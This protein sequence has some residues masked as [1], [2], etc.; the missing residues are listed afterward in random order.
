MPPKRK[1]AEQSSA[2]AKPAKKPKVATKEVAAKPTK[3]SAKKPSA[4]SVAAP[5]ANAVPA[6][7]AV[8]ATIPAAAP[9]AKAVALKDVAVASTK[10]SVK[11]V[12]AGKFDWFS[13]RISVLHSEFLP[14]GARKPRYPELYAAI[15][16]FQAK[17]KYTGR[18]AL[19]A[20]GATGA[21]DCREIENPMSGEPPDDPIYVYNGEQSDVSLSGKE[22]PEGQEGAAGNF[23][24]GFQC[25]L[26]MDVGASGGCS[27]GMI[28]KIKGDFKMHRVWCEGDKELFEG[29]MRV[30]VTHGAT[31]RRKGHPAS[32]NLASPIWAVRARRNEKGEEIGIDEGDGS[33]V[34]SG[35]GGSNNFDFDFDDDEDEFDDDYGYY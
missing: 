35:G 32:A 29:Y 20:S 6:A 34:G 22:M 2:T 1:A 15:L 24:H 25:D 33:F 23:K 3:S 12:Y 19:A 21:Y 9:I 18:L 11:P 31:L 10:A 26:E 13:T 27:V 7:K 5:K 28:S 16:E 30:T 17:P 4:K 14:A 8:P